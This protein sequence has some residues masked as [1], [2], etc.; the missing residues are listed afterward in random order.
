M[1]K[2]SK[3]PDRTAIPP[4]KL[5]ELKARLR[6][7]TELADAARASAKNAKESLKAAKKLAK[8]AKKKAKQLRKAA[9]EIQC[10]LEQATPTRRSAAKSRPAARKSA[11]SSRST[12]P[13]PAPVLSS[14]PTPPT[15]E[16]P[17]DSPVAAA[18]TGPAER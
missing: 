9:Q 14:D 10:E 3:L 8:Q 5:T 17:V 1:T 6:R 13:T 16:V 2:K 15:Q 7:V 18:E 4:V 12:K 11:K